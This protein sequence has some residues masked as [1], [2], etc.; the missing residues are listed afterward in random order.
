[1]EAWRSSPRFPFVS[2]ANEMG[3]G[4]ICSYSKPLAIGLHFRKRHL[5]KACGG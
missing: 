2:L 4:S 1:M 5:F 3:E